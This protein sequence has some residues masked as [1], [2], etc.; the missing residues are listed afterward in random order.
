MD[1]PWLMLEKALLLAISTS[2]EPPAGLIEMVRHGPS[3]AIT[4]MFELTVREIDQL[5]EASYSSGC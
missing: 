4:N 2:N 5:A 3:T 1:P